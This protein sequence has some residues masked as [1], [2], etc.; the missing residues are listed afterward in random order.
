[1]LLLEE[2]RNQIL[3][4][5]RSQMNVQELKKQKVRARLS[6]NH[7]HRF[8]LIA[9]NSARR[10]RYMRILGE[11]VNLAPCTIG[12]SRKSVPRHS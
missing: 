9:W 1:M 7:T 2:R 4:D 8:I 12:E 6:V 5:A 10:I 11:R 3:S